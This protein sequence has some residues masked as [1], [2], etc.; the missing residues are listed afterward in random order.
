MSPAPTPPLADETPP[1][2]ELAASERSRKLRKRELLYAGGGLAVGFILLPALIYLVGTI[3]LGPYAGGKS[4]FAFYGEFYGNLAHGTRRTW[5]I[6]LS[7]Y[8]AIWL[9]R[10]SFRRTL[11]A[12]L[13]KPPS[14]PASD[15]APTDDTTAQPTAE[16][17]RREPFISP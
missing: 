16:R 12:S 9:T 4:M 8:L 17:K 11:F 5:F 2:D 13:G 7:P 14:P 15:T 10:L 3:L 1:P 6:A